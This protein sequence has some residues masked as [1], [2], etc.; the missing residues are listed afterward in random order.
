MLRTADSRRVEAVVE[1]RNLVAP[2]WES[3]R[4]SRRRVGMGRDGEGLWSVVGVWVE[5][6]LWEEEECMGMGEGVGP[7]AGGLIEVGAGEVGAMKTVPG[8]GTGVV[9][10]MTVME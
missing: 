7:L 5:R 1:V 10:G 6:S 8:F 9:P 2:G 3:A 4:I